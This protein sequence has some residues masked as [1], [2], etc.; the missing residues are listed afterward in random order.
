MNK[1]VQLY[2]LETI[3]FENFIDLV[4]EDNKSYIRCYLRK[5]NVDLNTINEIIESL[6]IDHG[7]IID[8]QLSDR[9][10]LVDSKTGKNRFY[11][12]NNGMVEY[13][14]KTLNIIN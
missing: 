10:E 5:T 11:I 13:Y 9:L 8:K 12:W 6:T 1:F 14:S 2:G 4:Y 3:D 7:F